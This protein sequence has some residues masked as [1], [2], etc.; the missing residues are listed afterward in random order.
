MNAY[1][2]SN[3]R[4]THQSLRCDSQMPCHSMF[5]SSLFGLE[6]SLSD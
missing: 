3:W 4:T 5:E 1:K 6:V 2:C